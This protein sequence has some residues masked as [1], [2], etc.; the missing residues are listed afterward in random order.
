MELEI[1]RSF[2]IAV[3][4]SAIG[5]YLVIQKGIYI[6]DDFYRKTAENHYVYNKENYIW[7]KSE[8]EFVLVEAGKK[9]T[10]TCYVDDSD[11]RVVVCICCLKK[12]NIV[13][14][15]KKVLCGA[16]YFLLTKV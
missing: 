3:V 10:A 13:K 11:I 7:W 2:L 16:S 9:K 5:L 4:A 15:Y 6:G 14:K 12:Y 8:H 1:K